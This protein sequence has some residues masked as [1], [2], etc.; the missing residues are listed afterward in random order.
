MGA[1]IEVAN[2]FNGFFSSVA[3]GPRPTR[4]GVLPTWR[5][6]PVNATELEPA[7]KRPTLFKEA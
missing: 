2:K 6:T 1:A 4:S 3:Q 5:Q 7:E